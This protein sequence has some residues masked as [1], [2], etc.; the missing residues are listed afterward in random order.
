MKGT[1]LYGVGINDAEYQV[2]T[3]REKNSKRE[4]VWRCP[5]Y[6]KWVNML[7]R[8]YGPQRPTY[9]DVKVCPEWKSFTSFKSW[10]QTQD[11]E[12]KELDKDLRGDGKL[13]SPEFC[14]FVSKKVN[15]FIHFKVP[16]LYRGYWQ[17]SVRFPNKTRKK[18]RRKSRE[19]VFKEYYEGKKLALSML[20]EEDCPKDIRKA[21][22]QKLDKFYEENL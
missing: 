14:A 13:Y 16:E 5:Y 21:V 20:S 15:M 4:I 7:E 17:I 11:W 2:N 22:S 8:A 9:K 18:F 19:G 1:L 6:Q 3:T 12:G 10:M